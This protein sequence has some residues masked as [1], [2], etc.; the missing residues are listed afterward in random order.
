MDCAEIM[1]ETQINAPLE[2]CFLLSLSVD[3]HRKSV[4]W[5]NEEAID[6]ITTGIMKKNDFVTWRAKHFGIYMEMTTK[7]AQYELP[8]FFVS[9]MSKGPFKKLYHQ[10]FFKP[11]LLGT[12]MIDHF[13]FRSPLGIAGKLVD[14]LF[15][16]SYMKQ[17]LIKRNETIKTIAESEEW[18]SYLK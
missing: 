8:T 12:L 18:K 7:I 1:L 14:K 9:E 4:E 10:H 6:G 17:L 13:S 15:M 3:L 11:D 2:R 16:Q 5:S